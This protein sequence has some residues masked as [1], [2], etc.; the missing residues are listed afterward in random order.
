[1]TISGMCSKESG[2]E[3]SRT[4][5]ISLGR[6]LERNSIKGSSGGVSN[7]EHRSA[8][9]LNRT[10]IDRKIQRVNGKRRVLP[11]RRE[12]MTSIVR[13]ATGTLFVWVALTAGM[14]AQ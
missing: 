4:F 5:I 9:S 3:R 13:R 2:I 12:M 14:L 8:R 7:H 11:G 10:H 6:K 1:M